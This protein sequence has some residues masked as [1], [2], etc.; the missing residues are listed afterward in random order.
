MDALRGIAVWL[1]PPILA[2]GICTSL[3]QAG[4]GN[5]IFDRSTIGL[6]LAS[7]VFTVAGSTLLTLVFASM[8]CHRVAL[9]YICLVILGAVAG[10]GAMLILSGS[11]KFIAAGAI[12]GVV[13]ASLWVMTHSLIYRRD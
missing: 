8:Q 11:S 9:R 4:S 13:T 12:Y 2:S 1:L 5:S 3:W 7:F 10:A 6:G